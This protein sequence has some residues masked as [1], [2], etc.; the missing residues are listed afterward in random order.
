MGK[1][2]LASV[3][4]VIILTVSVVGCNA[5]GGLSN[6]DAEANVTTSTSVSSP[7]HL[8]TP[9]KVK[10]G[11]SQ[12]EGEPCDLMP[13]ELPSGWSAFSK[14]CESW[15]EENIVGEDF[16]GKIYKYTKIAKRMYHNYPATDKV[17]VK[18]FVCEALGD[19]LDRYTK[20]RNYRTYPIAKYWGPC[21]ASEDGKWYLPDIDNC[22]I[23]VVD[24]GAAYQAFTYRGNVVMKAY[25]FTT[26]KE[27]VEWMGVFSKKIVEAT[28]AFTL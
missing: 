3:G 26:V 1:I 9:T 18:I 6:S 22:I 8:P 7:T 25:W 12:F 2:A 20:E 10:Y 27:A 16:E 4:L 24:A 15:V 5:I 19:T 14:R 21:I 11:Y 17:F 28:P 23:E 13:T